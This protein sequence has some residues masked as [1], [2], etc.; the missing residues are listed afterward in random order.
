MRFRT[1]APRELEHH[2]STHGFE[3]LA[4]YGD[5]ELTDIDLGGVT[6]MVAARFA[7]SS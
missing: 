2:L 6:L 5:R 7:G 4:M 1:L 3:T